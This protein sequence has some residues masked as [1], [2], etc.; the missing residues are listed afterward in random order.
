[1]RR[2]ARLSSRRRPGRGA[3]YLV[4]LAAA[5]SRPPGPAGHRHHPGCLHERGAGA[6]RPPGR[7]DGQRRIRA[8]IGQSGARH[9][10]CG[11]GGPIRPAPGVSGSHLARPR[12]DDRS[13]A[14]GDSPTRRLAGGRPMLAGCG[15]GGAGNGRRSALGG[16]GQSRGPAGLAQTVC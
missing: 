15:A 9:R 16:C 11:P 13:P 3:A 12:G 7:L 6:G 4:S 2:R 14:P 1:M 8:R 5:R 10:L